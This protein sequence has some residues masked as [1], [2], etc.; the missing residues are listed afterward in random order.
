MAGYVSNIGEAPAKDSRWISLKQGTYIVRILPPNSSYFDPK[1][2]PLDYF[3]YSR[4]VIWNFPTPG[5][6]K[7]I[8]I[9]NDSLVRKALNAYQSTLGDWE[10]Q[11]LLMKKNGMSR[12]WPQQRGVFN[13]IT[14]DKKDKP[15]WIDLPKTAL[16]ELVDKIKADPSIIDLDKGR[17]VKIEI[18]GAGQTDKKYII[19]VS[20]KPTPIKLDFD[21]TL[22]D[23]LAAASNATEVTLKDIA[24]PTLRQYA[25]EI[26]K[27]ERE[28][29]DLDGAE[30]AP[31]R[32]PASTA[33]RSTKAAPANKT[34]DDDAFDAPNNTK[35]DDDFGM[36]AFESAAT[37]S[38]D[39]G[40]QETEDLQTFRAAVD[41][42]FE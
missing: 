3:Y 36:E 27:A 38:T 18:V 26:V 1:A 16:K 10:T 41:G 11:R 8:I 19:T 32:K 22:L 33:Q 6:T 5:G 40:E 37:T 35:D 29:Q 42:D 20:N 12:F 15:Y 13:V 23:D 2:P 28:A 17:F 31:A 7:N 21:V 4:K 9:D 30:A 24:D 14:G 39:K 25:A 34:F